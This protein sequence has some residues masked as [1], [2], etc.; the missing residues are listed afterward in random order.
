MKGIE[1][2]HGYDVYFERAMLKH[3]SSTTPKVELY[4]EDGNKTELT[5]R[6][7]DGFA[8]QLRTAVQGIASGQLPDAISAQSARNSLATV[9]AEAESVKSGQPVTL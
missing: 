8:E 3:N 7:S 6:V 5:P 1:F 4:T 2:E 9:L